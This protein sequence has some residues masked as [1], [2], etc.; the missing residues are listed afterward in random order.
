M[1]SYG[2]K[3]PSKLKGLGKVV[4]TLDISLNVLLVET[5]RYNLLSVLQ[6]ANQ[7]RSFVWATSSLRATNGGDFFILR[8]DLTSKNTPLLHSS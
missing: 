1:V 7:I 2:D 8:L 5:L 3:K 6:L 4:V